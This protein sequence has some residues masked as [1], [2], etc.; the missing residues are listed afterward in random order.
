MSK[1]WGDLSIKKSGAE[2]TLFVREIRAEK[3]VFPSS[4]SKSDLKEKHS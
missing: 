2:G 3:R 1:R 4:D